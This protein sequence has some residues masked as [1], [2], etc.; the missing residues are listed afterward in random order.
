MRTTNHERTAIQS[1]TPTFAASIVIVDAEAE[2]EPNGGF[3]GPRMTA[4]GCPPFP[5]WVEAVWKRIMPWS[6]RS[7]STSI[8]TRCGTG[9]QS[10]DGPA[11]C[12]GLRPYEG[13]QR[14]RSKDAERPFQVVGQDVQAHL[15]S[16]PWQC[17]REEMGRAIHA[18]SVPKGCSA[19]CRRSR[20]ASG[21]RSRRRCM[22][23]NTCSCSQRAMRRYLLGVQRDF[24]EQRGQAELQYLWIVRPFSIVENRQIAR[25]PAGQRYSSRL[26]I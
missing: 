12:V 22:S 25:S 4:C 2:L 14:L 23:S 13:D 26:A 10:N 18:L 9:L 5:Q 11:W 8:I 6:A 21:V 16:D 1:S 19:V 17:L 7:E 20:E 24:I 3:Q 15:S